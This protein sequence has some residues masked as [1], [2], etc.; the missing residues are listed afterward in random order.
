MTNKLIAAR[1][2]FAAVHPEM[3]TKLN[4]REWGVM[5]MGQGPVL[6]LIPGTL[7]RGDIFWQQMLALKNRIRIIAVTYPESGGIPEWS[8]DMLALMDQLE[9]SRA[10]VL[11]SSLGGYLAQYLAET[12]PDRVERLVGAN[13]L[14]AVQGID[15]RMPY[16]LDLDVVPVDE[17]R[18]GFAGGLGQW[19]DTHPEQADVVELLMGEVNGRIPEP[20]LRTRLKATKFAP[21]LPSASLPAD[22]TFTI[23]ADDDPLIPPEM[24]AL[25]RARL[26]PGVAYRFLNGGHFPYVSRPAEY[27]A[28]LE[29]VMELDAT[30][31]D[32]GQEKERRL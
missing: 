22:R 10:T 17:L 14:C 15:A 4:G 27:I 26:T 16:A 23:E 30:G 12:A 11:G 29:Q 5:D 1:D 24:R 2:A 25:V 18:G 20:E 19:V 31:V 7:G 21:D 13:T 6:L 8:K 9:V 32:W 28:L 3:R